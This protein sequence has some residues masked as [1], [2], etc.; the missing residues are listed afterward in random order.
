MRD[1]EGSLTVDAETFA[2]EA[3]SSL[4][5]VFLRCDCCAYAVSVAGF[6]GDDRLSPKCFVP[7]VPL[8]RNPGSQ[9]GWTGLLV[10]KSFELFWVDPASC[11][12][13]LRSFLEGLL[14]DWGANGRT[15]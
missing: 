13:C 5:H 7:A 3:P 11:A 2:V 1:E 8:I 4:F 10:E 15:L 12:N 6:M 9:G 14:D